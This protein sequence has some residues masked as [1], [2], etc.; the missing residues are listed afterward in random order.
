MNSS[1][2]PKSSCFS[3]DANFTAILAILLVPL[4]PLPQISTRYMGVEVVVHHITRLVSLSQSHGFMQLTPEN[5]Q[6]NLGVSK[7]NQQT[8]VHNCSNTTLLQMPQTAR[9]PA[10]SQNS[11][12]GGT[13]LEA[14]ERFGS[15][16]EIWTRS[17]S[18]RS[19]NLRTAICSPLP[20]V[21]GNLSDNTSASLSPTQMHYVANGEQFN[22]Y[23]DTHMLYYAGSHACA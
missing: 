3:T 4:Q 18:Q 9:T 1:V 2:T 5:R 6:S 20:V 8:P 15:L 23:T 17:P 21:T 19:L 10:R 12:D 14:H 13:A 22:T 7:V 16:T 11:E